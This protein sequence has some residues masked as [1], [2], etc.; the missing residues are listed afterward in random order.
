MQNNHFRFT[1]HVHI[2]LRMLKKN[3]IRTLEHYKKEKKKKQYFFL[4]DIHSAV[5]NVISNINTLKCS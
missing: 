1:V 5:M 2:L 3:I 4:Q